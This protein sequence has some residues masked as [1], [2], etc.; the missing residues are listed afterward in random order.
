[1]LPGAETGFEELP[2]VEPLPPRLANNPGLVNPPIAPNPTLA[3]VALVSPRPGVVG[4]ST[5]AGALEDE[6]WMVDRRG[7]KSLMVR[8]EVEGE[9]RV[10]ERVS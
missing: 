6:D 5:L 8:G 2:E 4:E 7:E 10:R 9:G 3:G 1:M